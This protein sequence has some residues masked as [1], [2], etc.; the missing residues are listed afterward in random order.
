MAFSKVV[1][2]IVLRN[3]SCSLI[4][5]LYSR[6]TISTQCRLSSKV[7]NYG[8]GHSTCLIYRCSTTLWRCDCSFRACCFDQIHSNQCSEAESAKACS[9]RLLGKTMDGYGYECAL[10]V[11]QRFIVA[12]V[13]LLIWQERA[14]RE[15]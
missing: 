15:F 14:L 12:A 13:L 8:A 4:R 9:I 11:S 1:A 6:K 10:H 7:P 5:G 3:L 2:T